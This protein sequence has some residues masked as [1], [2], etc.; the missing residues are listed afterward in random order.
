MADV[1]R[2]ALLRTLLDA[3]GVAWRPLTESERAEAERQWRAVYGGAFAGRPRLRHGARAEFEFAQ[4]FADRWLI[5][6]LSS[7]VPG[8]SVAPYGAVP[9][10]YEC[11][12]RWCRW[13]RRAMWNSRSRLLTCPGRCCTRTRITPSVAPTSSGGIG[14]PDGLD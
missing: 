9:T 12:G 11:E 5:V 8:T 13:E 14:L 6:P 3:A 1:L 4:Q 2:N 7:G 10:G